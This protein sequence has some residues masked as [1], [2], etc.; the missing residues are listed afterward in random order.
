M[1]DLTRQLRYI[2]AAAREGSISAAAE[3]EAI[4]PSSILLA[5]DKFESSYKTQ[6]F[7]RLKSK[8]LR[9]TADGHAMIRKINGLISEFETLEQDLLRCSSNLDGNLRVGM[10]STF[11]SMFGP[12]ILT[13]LSS[14]YPDLTVRVLAGSS[15]EMRNELRNGHVDVALTYDPYVEDGLE[16]KPLLKAPAYLAV[17]ESD[18]LALKNYVSIQDIAHRPVIAMNHADVVRYTTS[19]LKDHGL[20]SCALYKTLPF[21]TIRSAAALGIGVGFLHLRPLIDVTY[22]GK[23]VVCKPIVDASAAPS[24]SIVTRSGERLS[25]RASVFVDYCEKFFR[26]EEA[27]AYSV[28]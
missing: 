15:T 24:L 7:V 10:F 4:S 2:V 6:L 12:R 18:P 26:S 21:E 8:G 23:R 25:K 28:S 19:V 9:L 5:I 3:A 27:K 20:G 13:A 14:T 16:L 17:G 11:S 1:R 22:S